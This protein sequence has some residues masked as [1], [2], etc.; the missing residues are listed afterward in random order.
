MKN[1]RVRPYAL[2]GAGIVLDQLTKLGVRLWVPSWLVTNPGLSFSLGS[3]NTFA[4]TAALVLTAA[5]LGI[6][7]RFP[8]KPWW[9]AIFVAG[10]VGNALDRLIWG[11]VADFIRYPIGITGNTADLL[12]AAGAAGGIT[13]LWQ[14]RRG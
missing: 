1:S 2:L 12:L 9:A 3:G 4:S 8:A 7:I 6:F 13:A 11:E 14:L 5:V 10:A